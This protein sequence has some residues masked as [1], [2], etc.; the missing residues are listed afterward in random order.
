MFSLLILLPL[1]SAIILNMP[2]K[3]QMHKAAFW[4]C[5]TLFVVQILWILLPLSA[6]FEPIFKLNLIID[7]LSRVV[8]FC[9]GMVSIASLFVGEHVLTDDDQ[10]FNFLNLLIL[11]FAG[12]NGVVMVKDVFSLYV[13][14]EIT[15]VASFVLIALNRDI[16]ALE[17]AFKYMIL[18]AIATVMMLSSIALLLLVSGD[19]S[20]S[21]INAAI[22]TSPH[23]SL[24]NLAMGLFICGLLIKGGLM[25]F[26]GW[27]PDAYTAAPAP[28]SVLLGGIVTKTVGI[29]ALIRIVTL[30][31]VFDN[32]LKLLLMFV[33]AFSIVLGA[34]AALGQ[35]DMKKMLSYSSIS[36]VGY[37]VIGLGCGTP[38]SVFGAIFHLLNHAIFKTLLF[39]NSAAVESQTGSRDMDKMSGLAEKMPVTG[40]TSLLAML[41][42]SGIPPLS[43]FWSKLII[44]MALWISGYYVFAVIAV[45]ASVITLAYFLSMQRRVFFGKISAELKNIKE[46]GFKLVF[47]AVMLALLIVVIG[48]LFPF[49][50][51]LY[52][53]PAGL[54]GG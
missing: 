31:F 21:G 50:A 13:F 3:K 37:I 28:V 40:V 18:S 2:F 45:S 4:V 17:A 14:L 7:D 41:S 10:R 11:A 43:G 44:V 20:F 34:L 36:Q 9:I 54:L 33:G 53:N 42:A 19:T 5:L 39:V 23:S 51:G 29:Y 32:P 6:T 24:I 27:L 12:M 8:L 16:T 52:V 22:M 15:A 35:S 49:L 25:P 47:P 46:A 38:L 26:H 1:L 30:V 48:L